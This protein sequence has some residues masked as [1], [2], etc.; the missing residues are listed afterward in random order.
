MTKSQPV[1]RRWH[2]ET[3]EHKDYNSLSEVPKGHLDHH[4][5][6][7]AHAAA[8]AAAPAK[9]DAPAKPSRT[10]RL[11]SAPKPAA[12]PNAMSRDDVVAALTEGGVEFDNEAS[13]ADLQKLLDDKVRAV[14]TEQGVEFDPNAN[15]KTLLGLL[16]PAE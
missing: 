15:T 14:L 2:P 8:E 9:S 4:P 1:Y 13:D 5:N 7:E 6:D 12:D 3:G 10:K 16:S 11:Q